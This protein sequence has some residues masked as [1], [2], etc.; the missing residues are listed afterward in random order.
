[1]YFRSKIFTKS[2]HLRNLSFPSNHTFSLIYPDTWPLWLTHFFGSSFVNKP[3]FRSLR[4]LDPCHYQRPIDLMVKVISFL[5]VNSLSLSVTLSLTHCSCFLSNIF[6]YTNHCLIPLHFISTHFLFL[7]IN[8][9]SSYF[10]SP[11]KHS[12]LYPNLD[13]V[14]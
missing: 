2:T 6:T 5:W 11:K 3:F 8:L 9:N 10:H 12:R 14:N 1:M 13:T 7:C 4:S